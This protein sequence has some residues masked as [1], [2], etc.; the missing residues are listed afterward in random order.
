EVG[1][2]ADG[3]GQEEL[4]VI[5]SRAGVAIAGGRPRG[6]L[7]GVYTFLEDALGVRFLTPEYTHVPSLDDETLLPAMDKSYDPPF[8]FRWSAFGEISDNHA[9][10]TRMRTN[11]VQAEEKFGGKTP[12]GLVNHTFHLFMP[13]REYGKDHPEYFNETEG[14]RPSEVYDDHYDPGVQLCTTNPEVVRIVKE[15]VLKSLEENPGQ[16]NVSV[17]QND[18]DH[19]C[20]CESCH[21]I[22]EREGSHMGSHLALV[23][24]V[25]DA[26]ADK[27]P[28]VLVGTLAYSYTRKPP[29]TLRPGPNVQIQ[30]CSIECCQTHAIDD[31]DCPKNPSFCED[32][33]G[34]GRISDYIS[35]WTYVTNFHFYQ[36]PCPNLRALGRNVRFF[37]DNG[38]KGL[39]MQGP[40]PAAE[41]AGLRN[42]LISNLIWDPSRDDAELI[43][44]FLRLHYGRGSKQVREYI[45]LVHDAAEQGTTH[46]NCF[47]TAA[48]HGLGPELGR[49]GLE[50]FEMAMEGAESDEVRNRLEKASMGCHAL[51]V[52]PVVYR[53]HQKV[54]T[55]KRNRD[56]DPLELDPQ[57]ARRVRPHLQTFFDLCR[58]HGVVNVG[59]WGTYQEVEAVLREW[60]GMEEGE[61]F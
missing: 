13:W 7:Y 53:A 1:F 9:F 47:G 39:F 60:Y 22:D 5:V 20:Q 54:R 59:E 18:N 19:M 29:S 38:V 27:H 34:W 48:D 55:R 31:P 26:V 45:D 23:N 32:L 3:M 56:E 49:R 58:R 6:T 61:A 46:R 14:E 10:A 25:A 33:E 42:Y 50:I 30:L 36:L 37:H 57:V 16:G 12:I 8:G 35:V 4:R 51:I 52:E 44:E 17:S 15:R 41:L 24:S 40:Y 2:D 21:D 11:T 43:E 28:G